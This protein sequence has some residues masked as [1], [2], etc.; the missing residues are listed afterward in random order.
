MTEYELL[1]KALESG[2]IDATTLQLEIEMAE[3]KKYLEM[4]EQ[5]VWQGTGDYWYTYLPEDGKRRLV[6]KRKKKDLDDAIVRFYRQQEINPTVEEIFNWWVDEKLQIGE[7]KKG[8][9]DRYRNEFKVHFQDIKRRRIH[10][11]DEDILEM[12]IRTS[13]VK[14]NM[15][16]KGY[17]GF[18]TIVLGMFKYAKRKKFSTISISQFFQDLQLSRTIF[19]RK[20]IDRRMQVFSNDELGRLKSWIYENKNV[21]RLGILLACQTG[22][23]T[24]ELAALKFSDIQD[25]K[26]HIC[27]QEIRY[28]GDNGKTVHEIVEY[29]KTESGDRFVILTDNAKAIL[30]EIRSMNDPY[31][32]VMTKPDGVKLRC[33]AFDRLL[34]TACKMAGIKQRSMHKLRKTFG[35]MLIDSGTEDSIV[36]EMMGHSDITTTR[37][38]YYFPRISDE[39]V[40]NRLEKAVGSI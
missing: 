15:S 16:S 24:A 23:R 2:I 4:H 18:R 29:T 33:D 40:K 1:K 30:D 10:C 21:G 14:Y 36:M 26:I 9:Y 39:E 31:E 5:R 6:K 20:P 12:F 25:N 32:F 37:K 35:T 34:Y 28:K 7:I 11:I 19:A 17:S 38:Y 27:R 13:V 8:T 22:M 3:R